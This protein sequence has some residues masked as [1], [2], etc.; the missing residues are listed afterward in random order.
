MERVDEQGNVLGFSVMRVSTLGKA[1][2]EVAL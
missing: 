2:L 1:P